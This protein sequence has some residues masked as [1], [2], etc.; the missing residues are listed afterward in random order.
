MCIRDRLQYR[1]L[2]QPLF[3]DPPPAIKTAPMN[4]V[5]RTN[6]YCVVGAGASGITVA[7]NMLERRQDGVPGQGLD[8]AEELSLIHI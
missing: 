8:A 1:R 2:F 6:T 3:Y 4:A 7:K 5:D